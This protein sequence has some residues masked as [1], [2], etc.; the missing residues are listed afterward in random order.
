MRAMPRLFVA[1]DFPAPVREQLALICFGLK[2]AR[3]TEK[4]QMHLTV[5]FIGEVE[6]SQFLD[7]RDALEDVVA[8]PFDLHLRGLGHFPPRGKPQV[9]WAGVAGSEALSVLHDRVEAAVVRAGRPPEGRK[10]HAHVTLARL[11]GTH[12]KHVAQYLGHNALFSAGPF[13][14]EQFH[15]YSSVL[16]PKGALH[17]IEATYPLQTGGD[18][19][20]WGA[21]GDPSLTAI[22]G[23]RP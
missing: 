4:D 5:R 20:D 14:V 22:K 3:W 18:G 23:E 16:S 7:V 17:R 2:D 10:F 8:P 11:K 1:I 6:G 13:P 19:V 9:L 21:T 15:L 12:T